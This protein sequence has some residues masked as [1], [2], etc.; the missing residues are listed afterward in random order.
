M[1]VL[2]VSSVLILVLFLFPLLLRRL[3]LRRIL[4][5]IRSS[6]I[7]CLCVVV[8]VRLLVWCC[9]LF[10]FRILN[11]SMRRL[12]IIMLRVLRL[13]F[14]RRFRLVGRRMSMLFLMLC[15]VI[16]IC[17]WRCLCSSYVVV[18][19]VVLLL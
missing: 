4:C 17:I 10:G 15:C 8:C 13:I 9:F 6:V 16:L 11:M 3:L 2:C 1:C 7:V 5:V 19:S 18:V 14:I 12:R